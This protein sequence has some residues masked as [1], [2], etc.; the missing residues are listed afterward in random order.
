MARFFS[1][2]SIRYSCVW[3]DKYGWIHNQLGLDGGHEETIDCVNTA[4]Y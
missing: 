2:S 3:V 4:I 1:Y